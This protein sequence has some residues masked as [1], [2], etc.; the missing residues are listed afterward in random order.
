M[1]LAEKKLFE[2]RTKNLESSS[3]AYLKVERVS[4]KKGALR[5]VKSDGIAEMAQR[6]ETKI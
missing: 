2:Q 4:G 6:S 1:A 5:I 3:R